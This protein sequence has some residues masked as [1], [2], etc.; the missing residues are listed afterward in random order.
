M[1]ILPQENFLIALKIDL[2]LVQV[3]QLSFVFDFNLL[4]SVFETNAFLGAHSTV[5]E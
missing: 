1:D 5:I 3:Y 4:R 2:L